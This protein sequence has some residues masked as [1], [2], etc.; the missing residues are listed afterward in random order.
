MSADY[1][2]AVGVPTKSTAVLKRLIGLRPSV[3]KV[4]LMPR[5]WRSLTWK[6]RIYLI[7]K[8]EKIK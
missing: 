6:I 3:I 7:R 5:A 1:C 8:I 2:C 4:D